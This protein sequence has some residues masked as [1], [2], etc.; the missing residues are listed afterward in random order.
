[1]DGGIRLGWSRA[2]TETGGQYFQRM[3]ATF[4]FTWRP[5]Y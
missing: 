1:M 4:L 3:G 5:L 2:E